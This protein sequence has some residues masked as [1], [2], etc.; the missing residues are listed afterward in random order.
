MTLAEW[1]AAMEGYADA[2]MGRRREQ[3]WVVSHLLVAAGCEPEKVTPAKL[4]GEKEP[5][6]KRTPIFDPWVE[7]QRAAKMITERLRRK[8]KKADANI[9]G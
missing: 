1:R 3:A 5:K 9:Q 7:Q 4:L 8:A 2:T 6:P